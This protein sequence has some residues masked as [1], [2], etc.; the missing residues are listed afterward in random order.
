MLGENSFLI[1]SLGAVLVGPTPAHADVNVGISIGTP[2]PPP[3]VVALPPLVLVPASSV[4]YAPGVSFNLFVFSGR[5]YSFHEGIWFY[6][7]TGK[8]PWTV[9]AVERV[10]R[11][12]LA[13]PV[14]YYKIPPG[15]A[16]KSHGDGPEHDQDHPG[17]GHGKGKKGRD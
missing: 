13:V 7:S 10:P 17:K 11:A 12:V 14:A 8:G 2:A 4:Y 16:K 3:V 15:H 5:Y 1:L 6:S 9:L